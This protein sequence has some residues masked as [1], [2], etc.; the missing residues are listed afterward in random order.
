MKNETKKKIFITTD[1]GLVVCEIVEIDES[2]ERE[3]D[4]GGEE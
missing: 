4:E 1:S 2:E 3:T